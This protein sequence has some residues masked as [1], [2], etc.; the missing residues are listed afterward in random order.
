MIIMSYNKSPNLLCP[1]CPDKPH[2]HGFR[3]KAALQ[4]HI[5]HNHNLPESGKDTPNYT[6][7]KVSQQHPTEQGIRTPLLNIIIRRWENHQT[8]P[9]HEGQNP[10]CISLPPGT[11]GEDLY[12]HIHSKRLQ[13]K[14]FWKVGKPD[15]QYIRLSNPSLNRPSRE[16]ARKP[17]NAK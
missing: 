6:D 1:Y 12:K 3:S 9:I 17:K 13:E 8:N 15:N 14:G 2:N 4:H 7:T 11:P 16:D 5:L 10:V